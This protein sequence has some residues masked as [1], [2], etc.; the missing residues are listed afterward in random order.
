MI[1]GWLFLSLTLHIAADPKPDL[2]NRALDEEAVAHWRLAQYHESR[3]SKIWTAGPAF[4]NYGKAIEIEPQYAAPYLDRGRLYFECDKLDEALADYDAAVRLLPQFAGGFISRGDL[5]LHRGDD[6]KALSDFDEAIR[7]LNVSNTSIGVGSH[8]YRIPAW[9]GLDYAHSRR[10]LVRLFLKDRT[11]AMTD[12]EA[13]I[14]NLPKFHN[15]S[16]KQLQGAN[17]TQAARYYSAAAWVLATHPD[18]A[19]RD[20]RLAQQLLAKV[21]EPDPETIVA[22]SEH[23]YPVR[24][25][26]AAELGLFPE[27]ME[28]EKKYSDCV[29]GMAWGTPWVGSRYRLEEYEQRRQLRV[30]STW[31]LQE[32]P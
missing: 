26:V 20:G 27:A 11:A 15:L 32:K 10:C 30:R 17:R 28:W 31:F 12:L 13:A 24:A 22:A 21:Q 6:R 2:A 3:R 29:S 14:R 8:E 18:A 16:D 25:A 5:H 4:V 7:L 23:T 9:K 19:V 1:P